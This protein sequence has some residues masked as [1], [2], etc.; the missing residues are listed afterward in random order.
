MP[1]RFRCAYCNQ[2][3]GIARRK[4]G[5][6]VSCPKC[7]GQV[8]V[9][10]PE[11]D[12]GHDPEP[13]RGA[14]AVFEESDFEKMFHSEAAAPQVL[15]PPAP[16]SGPHLPTIKQEFEAVPLPGMGP[17]GV[18]FTPGMLTLLCVFVVIL[19]GMAFFLGLLLGRS[20]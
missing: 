9:P 1:I 8:V 6:V 2:L 14:G 12:D 15:S 4:A 19:M 7:N 5:T 17:R 20:N 11:G 3:M 10:T 16:Q 18:L 13:E